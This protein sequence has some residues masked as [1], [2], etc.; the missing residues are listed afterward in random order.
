MLMVTDGHSHCVF[1]V[2]I[3]NDGACLRGTV[4]QLLKLPESSQPYGLAFTGTDLYVSDSS[5]DGGII[6]LN[7]TT[8]DSVI[9]V[10]NGSPLCHTV[11]GIDVMNDGDVVFT[12]RGSRVIRVLSEDGVHREIT[13]FAGSGEGMP[14]DGS[15]FDA[16]FSQP[17]AVCVEGKTVF[18]TDTAA[19]AVK[20]I[21]P[22]TSLCKFREVLD[23]LSTVFGIHLRGV[24][25]EVHTIAEAVSSLT[26][27]RSMLEQWID[28]VQAKMG[29]KTAT[30]GPQGTI[31][32]KSRRSLEILADSLSVLGGFLDQKSTDFHNVLKLAATL[33]LVVE[34]FFSKMRSRNDMPTVLEFVHLFAP[35]IRE[36]LKQLTDTGFLYYTSPSSYYEA[37]ETMQLAF[38]ALPSVPCPSSV[39]M[40]KEDQQLMRDWRDNYGKPVRQLTVRNQ[41]TKD[42]VGTLPIFAYTTPDLPLQP[43]NFSTLVNQSV[44][45]SRSEDSTAPT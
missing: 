28:E 12:D 3:S 42:N 33:T 41:S 4:T 45:I 1:Q 17:T 26:K 18:V 13:E 9:I 30:Q 36:S 20:L 8:S 2:T 7:L 19:G 23:L 31:S 32:T 29:R 15:Y 16:S 5:S 39:Q 14:K 37:P 24:P 22:T 38:R 44:R 10:K 6:K 11:H 27:I 40:T 34:N 35:T 43:L 21:T 25:G